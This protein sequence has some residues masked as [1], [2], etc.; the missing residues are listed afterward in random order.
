MRSLRFSSLLLVAAL[1]LTLFLAPC[2]VSA[3]P[4]EGELSVGAEQSEEI[5]VEAEQPEE[6]MVDSKCNTENGE[7]LNPEAEA[8]ASTKMTTTTTT[9]KEEDPNCPSREYVIR[10]AGI[11][12]DVNK[13]GLLERTEL[14][15]AIDKLPWY[16]RGELHGK[17][18]RLQI[19][20]LSFVGSQ[21]YCFYRNY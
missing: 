6:M 16:G 10:C 18:D 20:V 4:S 17:H 21:S 11:H 9:T 7:C 13:N 1:C 5:P 2:E 14:Q 12:L 3:Q 19:C 8:A 15:A